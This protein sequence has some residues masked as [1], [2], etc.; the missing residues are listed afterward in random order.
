MCST[1][2]LLSPLF[3]SSASLPVADDRKGTEAPGFYIDNKSD[4]TSDILQD[5]RDPTERYC[6]SIRL[7][8]R[9]FTR[10]VL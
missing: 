6:S 8:H 2:L 4:D 7:H 1:Q 9:G 10:F 3:A 5:K